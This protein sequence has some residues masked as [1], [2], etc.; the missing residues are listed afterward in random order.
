MKLKH[1]L[2]ASVLFLSFFLLSW[3]VI[4][5]RTIGKIAQN[6]LSAKAKLA[7]KNLLGTENLP[8]VTTFADEL[9]PY[10]EFD[11]TSKWHYIN[12]PEGLNYKEFVAFLKTD[13]IPNVYTAV[14]AQIKVLK[15]VSKSN[16]EKK[17]ALK[18]LVHLVGD[19]HQP[20]HVSRAVDKGGNDIEVKFLNRKS[21]LHGVWDTGLIEYYGLSYTEMSTAF[22]AVSAKDIKKWQQDEITLWIYESY[23]ISEQLYAEVEKNTDLDYDYFPNHSEIVKKRLLQG[24]IRLAGL[25]NNI[26]K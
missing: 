19:L 17:F 9:R 5:H 15:D 13:T 10:Q 6:N 20:M 23:K 22:S 1:F 7:V 3:G 26:Y 11:F 4:G 16:Y 24:G 14:L 12:A 2:P 21:N 25:L 18:F 8:L